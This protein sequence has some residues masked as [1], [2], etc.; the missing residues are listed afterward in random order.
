VAEQAEYRAR[1]AAA[2]AQQHG[3]LTNATALKLHGE[4]TQLML[5]ISQRHLRGEIALKMV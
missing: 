3:L 5:P 2:R 4:H 1:V